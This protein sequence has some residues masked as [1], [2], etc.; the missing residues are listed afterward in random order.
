MKIF[1]IQILELK[2]GKLIK[3]VADGKYEIE[4]IDSK[5]VE[6]WNIELSKVWNKYMKNK[7]ETVLF[8]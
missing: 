4:T 2:F 8:G 1:F 6:W 5:V 3:L 7:R